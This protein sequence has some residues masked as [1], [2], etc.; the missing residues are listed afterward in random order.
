MVIIYRGAGFI[1]PIV[2]LCSLALLQALTGNAYQTAWWPMG[3][4]MLLA[5]IVLLPVGIYFNR[6]APSGEHT[7]YGLRME[8][9]SAIMTVIGIVLLLLPW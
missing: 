9:W 6:L 5:G 8:I 4:A 7:C 2:A 3:V 1:V